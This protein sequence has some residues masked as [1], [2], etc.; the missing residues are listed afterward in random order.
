MEESTMSL[1]NV[2]KY[3]EKVGLADR[4]I[5]FEESSATVELAA[6]A[7]GCEPKQIAKSLSLLVDG[8]PIIIIAAGNVKIDNQKFKA[9]FH[10]KAKMIPGDLVEEY[11]GHGPGGVCPFAVKP[12]VVIYMDVSLKQNEIVYPAA[13]SGNSAVRLSLKELEQLSNPKGWV[14]VCKYA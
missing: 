3:F 14:D 8:S 9:A 10:Q 7:I 5:V 6:K 13:G 12:D 11:I 1:E 4:I 2:K